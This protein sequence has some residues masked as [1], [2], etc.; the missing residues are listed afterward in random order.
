MRNLK[1]VKNTHRGVLPLVKLLRP[2]TLLK[3]TLLHGCFSIVVTKKYGNH[4]LR[5]FEPQIWNSLPEE[6]KQI[7]S[8]NAFKIYIKSWCGKKTNA[9]YVG[10]LMHKHLMS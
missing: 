7:S 4:S 8:L 6:I 3:V 10:N 2:A 1:N 9:T 5:V